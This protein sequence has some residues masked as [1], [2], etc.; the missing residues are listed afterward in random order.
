MPE[1]QR[2]MSKHEIS[3]TYSYFKG[4]VPYIVKEP[5]PSD[6]NLPVDWNEKLGEESRRAKWN[7]RLFYWAGF[8]AVWIIIVLIAD[9][10]T[11]RDGQKDDLSF[12][13]FFI[14]LWVYP[15][16]LLLTRIEYIVKRKF[17]KTPL[18]KAADQY[19]DDT[20]AY[21]YWWYHSQNNY[22]TS[23]NGYEFEESVGQIYS[24]HG[25]NVRQTKLSGDGGLDL[26]LEKDKEK[27]GVQCKAHKKA[28]GPSVARDLYGTIQHF[29][30]NRGILVSLNGFTKGVYTFVQGKNI[31]L[32]TVHD[33]I[34]MS[35]FSEEQGG[36]SE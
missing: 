1:S 6:Y 35:T 36:G 9:D 19:T 30:Y 10:G 11:L 3:S 13:T 31:E 7:Y 24:K 28:V 17:I 26:I 16:F 21:L 32:V 34:L 12:M 20:R 5:T 4:N 25:F 22:W 29:G 2:Y 15:L 8:I 14:L 23:L 27:T 33:L 18:Q